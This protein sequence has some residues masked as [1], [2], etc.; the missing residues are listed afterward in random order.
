VS[1]QDVGDRGTCL[2]VTDIGQSPLDPQVSP[3]PVFLGETQNERGDIHRRSRSSRC[4]VRAAIVL[5]GDQLPIPSQQGFRRDDCRD[6][7]QNLPAQ[8]LRLCRKATAL[9]IAV[10]DSAIADLFSKNTI[11]LGEIFND[12]LLML[13]HPAG[14]GDDQK[15]K[16]IQTR[17]YFA[18]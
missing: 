13:V 3:V 17:A 15:R 11:F 12:M 8:L 6:L 18:L 16:W 9:I 7:C 14:Y 2:R 1:L 10:P 5:L 4:T